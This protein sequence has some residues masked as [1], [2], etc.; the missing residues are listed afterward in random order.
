MKKKYKMNDVEIALSHIRSLDTFL[1]KMMTQADRTE[2]PSTNLDILS[3]M[4]LLVI[5]ATY[6]VDTE[7]RV[8]AGR[9]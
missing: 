3:R 8:T 9:I 6:A 4:L 1:K 7:A 5:L 2:F